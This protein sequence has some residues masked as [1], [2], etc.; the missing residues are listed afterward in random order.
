M[1]DQRPVN[2]DFTTFKLPLP[3]ITS[4]LHRISGAFLFVGVALLLYLLDMSLDSAEGFAT[5]SEWLGTPWVK[6]LTWAVV[7]ALLYH[8][9]AGIKHLIMDLGIGESLQGG[10]MG[11]RIV[12]VVSALSMLAAG[13]WIW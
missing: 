2:L 3:A 10:I 11:A 12:I 8:L 7:A 4:I 5:A 1:K 6:L 9:V 13:I